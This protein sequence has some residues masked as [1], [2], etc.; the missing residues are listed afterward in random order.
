MN[1]IT[2]FTS[3]TDGKDKLI[4]EQNTKSGRF[5]AFMDGDHKSKTWNIRSAYDRF[6]SPRRNSRAPKILSHEFIDTEYSLWLDGNIKLIG[7]A[8]DL[9]KE[10][11]QNGKYDLAVC[12]HNC[13]DCIYEEA[14]L[15][16]EAKLDDPFLIQEQMRKYHDE[17]FGKHRGMGECGVIVRRH[18]S[19]VEMFNNFWWSEFCRFS[20]RDQFGFMYAIDKAGLKVNFIEP[21]VYHNPFFTIVEH[22]TPRA[23]KR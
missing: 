22:L 5:V 1:N 19:K 2:V 4:E 6:K 13:R 18:T 21:N 14:H 12:R 10:W 11:L 23:E 8:E 3:I 20:V 17:G 15:C 9:V 16:A 7:S